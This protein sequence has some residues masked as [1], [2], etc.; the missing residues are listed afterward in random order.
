MDILD[1]ETYCEELGDDK[2]IRVMKSVD[3]FSVD[4]RQL[5]PNGEICLTKGQTLTPSRWRILNDNIQ[6]IDDAVKELREGKRVRK[7]I[8]L[9]GNVRLSVQSPYKCV[10]IR[11]FVYGE[12]AYN[13]G[14]LIATSFGLS[15]KLAQWEGLKYHLASVNANLPVDVQSIVPCYMSPDHSNQMGFFECRE[16]NPSGNLDSD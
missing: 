15:L 10:N 2:I 8:H 9:G 6:E 14:T 16:C 7:M 13:K 11:Q 12:N 1:T 3:S 4:I 5:L